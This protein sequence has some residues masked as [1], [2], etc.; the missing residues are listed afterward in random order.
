MTYNLI[1]SQLETLIRPRDLDV[2]LWDVMWD[3][4]VTWS[5]SSEPPTSEWLSLVH[6]TWC[7]KHKQE[8]QSVIG[9]HLLVVGTKVLYYYTKVIPTTTL[10][11]RLYIPNH[12]TTMVQHI[13]T[14]ISVKQD[15]I[16]LTSALHGYTLCLHPLRTHWVLLFIVAAWQT[17]TQVWTAP[18]GIYLETRN[19]TKL[20]PPGLT[21]QS[22][23]HTYTS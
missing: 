23:V 15:Q 2:V 20:C 6:Y 11:Y 4:C 16:W 3:V 7:Y 17:T 14:P 9:H 18:N 12:I 10:Y 8:L 21:R 5:P 22:Y 19:V 1:Q 13:T